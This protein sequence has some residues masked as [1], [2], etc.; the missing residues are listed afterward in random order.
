M[1]DESVGAAVDD[2]MVG[3]DDNRELEE[4]TQLVHGP[5]P[6]SEP[7]REHGEADNDGPPAGAWQREIAAPGGQHPEANSREDRQGKRDEASI[8]VLGV[9][10]ARAKRERELEEPPARRA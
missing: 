5:G 4:A 9:A 10:P 8:A 1:A 2:S 3:L 7:G 6:Q